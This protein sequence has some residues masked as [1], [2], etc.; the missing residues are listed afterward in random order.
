MIE[1]F[2]NAFVMVLSC[3][4]SY[5]CATMAP[6]VWEEYKATHITFYWYAGIAFPVLSFAAAVLAVACFYY[7]F[8]KRAP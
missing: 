6:T 5:L 3:Y 4:M 8:I 1:K 2:E 7:T